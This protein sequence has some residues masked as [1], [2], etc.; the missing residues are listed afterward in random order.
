[1]PLNEFEKFE[2]YSKKEEKYNDNLRNFKQNN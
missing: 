2:R 1:M